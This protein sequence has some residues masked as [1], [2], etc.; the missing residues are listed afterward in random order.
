MKY[1]LSVNL[2][3]SIIEPNTKLH[4][5]KL[6]GFEKTADDAQKTRYLNLKLIDRNFV[7][8]ISQP[9]TYRSDGCCAYKYIYV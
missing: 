8:F 2:Y 9:Y 5:T 7:Y 4:G 3:Y 1:E 6:R